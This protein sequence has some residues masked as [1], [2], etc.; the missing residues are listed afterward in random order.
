MHTSLN[1]IIHQNTA[2]ESQ[3]GQ[4]LPTLESRHWDAAGHSSQLV[5]GLSLD[6]TV[7]KNKQP[8]TILLVSAYKTILSEEL[9]ERTEVQNRCARADR[10]RESG[11]R[12]FK[13]QTQPYEQ[14]I[15]P[16][17]FEDSEA[18]RVQVE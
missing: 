17:V 18:T 8:G 3:I 1:E 5:Q 6:G 4:E 16:T 2:C 14:Q 9:P 15:D 12:G 11:Q 7:K 10:E 13:L